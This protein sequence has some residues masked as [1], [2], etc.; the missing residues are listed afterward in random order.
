MCTWSDNKVR[1]LIAVKVLHTLLLNITAVAFKVLS[2]GSYAPISAP[3][4]PFKTI[5][6]LA[7]QDVLQ[8]C[9]RITPDITIGIKMSAFNIF[10][11]SGREKN[12][13]GLDPV[14][15]GGCSSTV[16]CL[17]AKN[18]II[19][20]ALIQVPT[21]SQRHTKHTETL[22]D[23]TQKETALDQQQHS[24][25]TQICQIRFLST[26]AT[27]STRGEFANFIVRPPYFYAPFCFGI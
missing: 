21:F 10:L 1:E 18:S 23:A 27:G 17:L 16:I 4:S 9:H 15:R 26:T 19:D 14:N 25:E 6:K 3:S 24:Y 22:I 8:S 5:L 2:L 11:T 12:H 13:W 20:S 7:L